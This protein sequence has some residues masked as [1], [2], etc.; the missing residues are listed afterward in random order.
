M[1]L[2][3]LTMVSPSVFPPTWSIYPEGMPSPW[4]SSFIPQENNSFYLELN[5]DTR[6]ASWYRFSRCSGID[7]AS[8]TD[9]ILG[10]WWG[11]QLNVGGRSQQNQ[12]LGEIKFDE[13]RTAFL[14]YIYIY[15]Y[16]LCKPGV[17]ATISDCIWEPYM[18]HWGRLKSKEH[19]FC[20]EAMPRKWACLKMWGE[21]HQTWWFKTHSFQLHTH[22]YIYTYIYIS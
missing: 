1:V 22:I 16:V 14:K 8:G 2:P 18:P 12:A 21:N 4:I 7:G 15:T 9:G 6:R 3:V 11:A 19:K 5:V 20:G 17:H 10:V 13:M